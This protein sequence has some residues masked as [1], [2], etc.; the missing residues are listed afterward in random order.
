MRPED[1]TGYVTGEIE[2]EQG[3]LVVRR[4]HVRYE[5]AVP[6]DAREH[7]ERVLAVHAGACPV[8]RTIGRCVDLATVVEYR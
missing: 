3:V 4:I 5:L 7:V 1:L 2:Q 6:R 8:A